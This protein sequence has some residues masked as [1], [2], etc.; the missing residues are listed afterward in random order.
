VQL[1]LVR[2]KNGS[3]RLGLDRDAADND[4]LERIREAIEHAKGG[5][6]TLSSF[7]VRHARLAFYDQLTGAFIVSPDA[8]FDLSTG[9]TPQAKASPYLEATINSSVEIS[10]SPAHLTAVVKLP[11][12]S[13][14]IT[15]DMSFTGLSLRALGQ[16]AKTFNFLVPLDLKADVTGH[17]VLEHGTFLKYADLG[18]GSSGAFY[19]LG[20]PLRI[21]SLKVVGRYDGVTGRLLVDDASLEGDHAREH[22]TGNGDLVFNA[23]NTLEKA[24]LN[25]T[26]DQFSINMPGVVSRALSLGRIY[27]QTVYTPGDKTI[28]LEK[29]DVSGGAMNAQ[30]KGAVVLNETQSPAVTVDGV[31]NPMQV[32]DFLH[33]WPLHVGEGAREW[34]STNILKGR[35]G[36]IAIHADIKAGMLDL[37]ALPDQALNLGVPLAGA[38]V[39]YVHGM[40]PMVNVSGRAT[41]LGDTF[42]AIIQSGNVGAIKVSNGDISIPQ[43]HA[44]GTVGDIKAHID[45]T[46][47]DILRLIDEKPLQYASKFN[48]DPATSQ[49]VTSNDVEV[50]VP[51]LRDAGTSEIGIAVKSAVSNMAMTIGKNTRVTGNLVNFDITNSRLRAVGNMALGGGAVGIDWTEDFDNKSELTSTIQTKGIVD[52]ATRAAL[53][54]GTSGIVT[55]PVGVTG[56]LFGHHGQI[57]KASLSLDLTQ[58]TMA[59]DI[60]NFRKPPG[61]AAAAQVSAQFLNDGSARV[62]NI[63]VT[64]PTLTTHGSMSFGADSGLEKLDLS[65][66]RAGPNN[67]FAISLTDRPGGF[68]VSVHGRSADGTG[69]G[70][71]NSEK[72]PAAQQA[73]QPPPPTRP[74]HAT[75]RLDHVVMREGILISDFSLD[76]SGVG[77]KPQS[78]GLSGMLPSK[79]RV[80]GSVAQAADGR[81]VEISSTDAGTLMRGLFGFDSVRGGEMKVDALLSP[82]PKANAKPVDYSGTLT[83]ENF[84]VLNQPF[85][86]RL[87]AAGSLVGIA[88]LLRGE[89]ITIDKLD[90]P[91]RANGDIVTVHD[92]KAEGPAVGISADGYFDRGSTQI[93]L[94]GSLA[95]AYGINSILGNIPLLGN[96]LTS[97]PGEGIIGM[98]YHAKGPADNPDININPLS[99]LAPG[100]F[101]RI[102]EGSAPTAP[103]QADSV[104]TP[105]IRATPTP[106]SPPLQ[107]PQ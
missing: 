91:F 41:L 30:L 93:D 42:K 47:A 90:M 53:G 5:A 32:T 20:S 92:A 86:S 6:S 21:R 62:D 1:T 59:V 84:K 101:R 12:N 105:T 69:I 25:L 16:N 88:D 107:V 85:L 102:F 45:G 73:P 2:T 100:I 29:F 95:P 54:L 10:G 8:N 27:M 3:L 98:T 43:L 19:G 31:I 67:D 52:D 4:V 96:L 15:G 83:I 13:G 39:V 50:K 76:A 36:P 81:H 87:F 51:M 82:Q 79:A 35:I 11:K 89:G 17:F 49:G 104:L 48:L 22:M 75:V 68:D 60:I 74:F 44:H 33:Y 72:P 37:P 106:R 55:G 103:S 7:A 26:A 58:A 40:T 38:T 24:T 28:A 61:T 78:I 64:G 71:S 99:A 46:L 34:M 9:D 77:D 56:T 18:I 23:N 14:P 57:R 66:V 94:K 80:T 70:R 97:K 65:D 63:A